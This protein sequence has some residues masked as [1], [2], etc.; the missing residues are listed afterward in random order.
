MWGWLNEM[1]P[2]QMVD[3]SKHDVEGETCIAE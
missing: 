3:T 2:I 1:Q